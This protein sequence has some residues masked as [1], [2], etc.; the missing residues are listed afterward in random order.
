MLM[1]GQMDLPKNKGKVIV[2]NKSEKRG[3][4]THAQL[5]TIVPPGPVILRGHPT[6]VG[7]TLLAP[8]WLRQTGPFRWKI[9]RPPATP[10]LPDDHSYRTSTA[11][12]SAEIS[13]SGNRSGARDPTTS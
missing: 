13:A 6:Q 3:H 4:S 9:A 5:R 11:H 12:H 7:P 2:Q 1:R 8:S 10:L